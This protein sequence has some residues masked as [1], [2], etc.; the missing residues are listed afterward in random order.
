MKKYKYTPLILTAIAAIVIVA[1][2]IFSN[3]FYYDSCYSSLRHDIKS[4]AELQGELLS[5]HFKQHTMLMQVVSDY[6]NIREILELSNSNQK[7]EEFIK[8]QKHIATIFREDAIKQTF[9]YEKSKQNFVQRTVLVDKFGEIVASDDLERLG[10]KTI[11]NEDMSKFSPGEHYVSDIISDEVYLEGSKFYKIATPIYYNGEYSG[12]IQNNIDMTYF[13]MTYG[14]EILPLGQIIIVDDKGEI[15]TRSLN[16]VNSSVENVYDQKDNNTLGLKWGSIDFQKQPAGYVDYSVNE[17]EKLCYYQVIDGTNWIVL[18]VADYDMIIEQIMPVLIFGVI[19]ALFCIVA[20]IIVSLIAYKKYVSP[21]SALTSLIEKAESGDYTAQLENK[22]YEKVGAAFNSIMGK[23]A[24]T[25]SEILTS[26][27]RSD[28]VM[29]AAKSVIFQWD[30]GN[31][32]IEYSKYFASKFGF[33][34]SSENPGEKFPPCGHIFG[35]DVPA[36]KSFYLGIQNGKEYSSIDVRIFSSEGKY[37]WCNVSASTVFDANHAPIKA[38]GTI[39]DIDNEKVQLKRGEIKSK[40]DSLTGL[41]NCP[42]LIVAVNDALADKK[43]SVH[44]ILL[45]SFDNIEAVKAGL[46]SLYCDAIISEAAVKIKSA[47]LSDDILGRVHKNEFVILI[48]N[49]YSLEYLEKKIKSLHDLL[50]S[51]F[52]GLAYGYEISI[53]IGAS[54]FPTNGSSFEYLY[55]LAKISMEQIPYMGQN[56]CVFDEKF[57][58]NMPIDKIKQ[59]GEYL[60][61]TDITVQDSQKKAF[62]NNIYEYSLNIL[63]RSTNINQSIQNVM[64]LIGTHF[65]ADRAYIQMADEPNA[66]FVNI[67]EWRSA[68]RSLKQEVFVDNVVAISYEE[69]KAMYSEDGIFFIEDVSKTHEMLRDVLEANSITSMIQIAIGENGKYLGFIGYEYRRG[70][71]IP[72]AKEVEIIAFVSKLIGIFLIKDH[73]DFIEN[74]PGELIK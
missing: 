20:M 53:K 62:F 68:D 67:H 41:L 18:S 31:N 5:R 43:N 14:D 13:D 39:I 35:D 40:L 61:H 34:P 33:I 6:D 12:F 64:G 42:A 22:G 28:L 71:H 65:F 38:V 16:P 48:T 26:N 17:I 32:I 73:V 44:G 27:M 19:T 23:L 66:T 70:K 60:Y 2:V 36:M 3:L 21:L 72:T 1:F 74:Y 55:G 47:F 63:Y 51:S 8:Q 57:I 58:L 24:V 45:V 15:V 30:I 54:T 69:F 9:D 52:A 56:F 46:G 25:S 4:F 7:G 49:L 59:A 29:D 10:E 37:I 11:I 50:F